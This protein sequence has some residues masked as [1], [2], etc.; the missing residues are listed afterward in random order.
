MERM[1][2]N[3]GNGGQRR[4]YGVREGVLAALVS[5]FAYAPQLCAAP[6]PDNGLA[7]LSLEQLA[8]LPVTSVSKKSEPLAD[9]AASVYVITSD[10]IRRSGARNLPEVLRLAPNLQVAQ[11]GAD[12][13]AISARG[14]DVTSADK[15]L[16]LIDG[17]IVYSPLFSGVFWNLQ[18]LMLENIDRIEVI[19]GPGGTLW[20]TNAVNGVINIITKKSGD[21]AG[22]LVTAGGGRPGAD[23]AARYAADLDDG[24]SYRVYGMMSDTYDSTA[25]SGAPLPDSTN[26]SQGGFRSDW[27]GIDRQFTLQ[28]DAYAGN[29]DQAAPGRARFTGMNLLSHLDDKLEG[30]SDVSLLAYYDRSTIYQP[31]DVGEKLDIADIEVQQALPEMHDQ[32]LVWG[33][34][35]RYAHDDV[36]N[37]PGST[38][39][40]LPAEVD[41]AWTSLFAQDEARLAPTWRLIIGAR[42]EHNPYT[43]TETLPNLRLAWNATADSLL[44]AAVSRAVRSPSRLDVDAFSP[45]Q[46]PFFL[47]GNPDFQSETA[48]VYELGYRAQPGSDWSYSVTAYHYNY[49]HLRT[50]N[51]VSIAPLTL[52]FGNDMTGSETGLEMWGSYQPLPYWRL[53]ASLNTLREGRSPSGAALPASVSIEGDDPVSEWTLRSSF[54]LPGGQELDVSLR[55]VAALPDPAVPAYTTGDVRYGWSIGRHLDCSILLQNL[56]GPAHVEFNNGGTVAEFGRGAY[57]KLAWRP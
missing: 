13:W 1:P 20:G 4:G 43:G 53:S 27:N 15:L 10:D 48:R 44:W 56:F 35:Y 49:F 8:N 14:G 7:D 18:N 42:L 55:H 52:T 30:G 32:D 38:T 12:T 41:Q 22:G 23:G 25:P 11:A 57:L 24:G 5:L 21:T 2:G 28:G 29:S 40:F 26:F 36:Q 3:K 33:A 31:E 37:L 16:V 34:S 45:E 50:E 54:D 47:V 51:L 46:P 6:E 19:S 17:R 39:A 9:A